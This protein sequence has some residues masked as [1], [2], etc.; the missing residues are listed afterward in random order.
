[1]ASVD[2]SSAIIYECHIGTFTASGTFDA[3][4]DRLDYLSGLGVTHVEL[5]PVAEFSAI[6]MGLRR[7]RS[8]A[9]HHTYG[10]PDGLKRFVDAAIAMGSG[11]F[12][13]S[14][15]TISAQRGTILPS[16]APIYNRYRTPW[17]DAVNLDDETA[18]RSG[19]SLR[20]R[21][22]VAA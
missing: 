9:P 11:L 20:Q 4:I 6:G 8:F 12:S 13:T 14:F 21:L 10:G 16:S 2:L 1:M 15:T 18:T 5:M 22:D 17:G 7:R 19:D 3:A